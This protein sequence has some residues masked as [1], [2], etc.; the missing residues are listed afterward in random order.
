MDEY[1]HHKD[2]TILMSFMFRG[3]YLRENLGH[4][5]INVFK[6]DN[7]KHYIYVNPHGHINDIDYG[8][9]ETILLVRYVGNNRVKIVAKAWGLSNPFPCAADSDRKNKKLETIKKEQIKACEGIKYGGKT[10]AEIFGFNVTND[11]QQI[12]VTYQAENFRRAKDNKYI[13]SDK[14]ETGNMAYHSLKGYYPSDSDDKKKKTMY[15]KLKDLINDPD[16]WEKEDN[17][18]KIDLNGTMKKQY[19]ILNVIGKEDDEL[20]FSNWFSYLFGDNK[21]LLL[22]FTNKVLGIKHALSRHANVQ[23]EIKNIDLLITDL[24]TNQIIVIEN[25][26]KSDI[27]IK[28]ETDNIETQ[29]NVSST[30]TNKERPKFRNQLHK[31]KWIAENEITKEKHFPEGTKV[32]CYIFIPDY[33]SIDRAIC[34]NE[35]Y[36]IIKYCDIYKFFEQELFYINDKESSLFDYYVLKEFVKALVRHK[37]EY[38]DHLFEDTYRLFME[39]ISKTDEG[40]E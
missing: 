5:I 11:R 38:P 21:G 36:T 32:I 16:Y 31:Y 29:E 6:A 19:N 25:K 13:V 8:K 26:I 3:N 28:R 30:K 23:R 27:I 12:L 37:S 4:E 40:L 17:S 35:G 9:T 18:E 34:V 14:D 1:G 24:E 39:K 20:A 33:S 22:R 10:L 15:S 2:G 7:E